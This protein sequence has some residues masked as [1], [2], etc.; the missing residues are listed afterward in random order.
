MNKTSIFAEF[1]IYGSDFDPKDI[2]EELAIIPTETRLKGILDKDRKNPNIE[3][4]WSICTEEEE[5]YDINVQLKKLIN[6]LI[7]KK[8]ILKKLKTN[9][10]NINIIFTIIIYIRNNDEPAMYFDTSTLKFIADIGSE[11]TFDLYIC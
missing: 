3:T 4:V 10:T 2:T 6:L 7:D 9:H 5:S 11:I 1:N 8:E